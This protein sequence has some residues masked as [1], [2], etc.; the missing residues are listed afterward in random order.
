MKQTRGRI[1]C[2]T[3]NGAAVV[4]NLGRRALT[5]ITTASEGGGGGGVAGT[6]HGLIPAGA[7]RPGAVGDPVA[8]GR[9]VAGGDQPAT[10]GRPV[11]RGIWQNLQTAIRGPE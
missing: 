7:V 9:D 8:L 2:E 6:S 10:A 3:K 1:G 5:I 11:G 4:G